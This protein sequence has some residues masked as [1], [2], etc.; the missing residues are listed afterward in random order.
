MPH[1]LAFLNEIVLCN[2][3]MLSMSLL[4]FSCPSLVVSYSLI[5][6]KYKYLVFLVLKSQIIMP[7]SEGVMYL[8]LM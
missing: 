8:G 7:T 3:I 6:V 2:A 5:M 1:I 4:Q